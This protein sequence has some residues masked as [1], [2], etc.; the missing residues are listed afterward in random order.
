MST[1]AFTAGI[2]SLLE[3]SNIYVN[4]CLAPYTICSFEAILKPTF[5]NILGQLWFLFPILYIALE[6]IFT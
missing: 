4:I 6:G 1:Y 3:T 5:F 2:L